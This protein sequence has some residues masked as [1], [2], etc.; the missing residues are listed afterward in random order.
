MLK[1][2][3]TEK[4]AD[5]SKPC[6]NMISIAKCKQQDKYEFLHLH[7]YVICQ[8]GN[9]KVAFVAPL[10]AEKHSF[11]MEQMKKLQRCAIRK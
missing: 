10:I 8:V 6:L 7:F 5:C 4:S 2:Y 9:S 11:V 1:S 3:L